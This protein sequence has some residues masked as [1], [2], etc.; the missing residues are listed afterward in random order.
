MSVNNLASSEVNAR[1]IKINSNRDSGLE[2]FGTV[3]I[4]GEYKPSTELST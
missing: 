2:L 1:S 4:C 3:A